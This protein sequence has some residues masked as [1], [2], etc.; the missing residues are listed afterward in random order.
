MSLSCSCDFDDPSAYAWYLEDHSNFKL[1]GVKD[2]RKR[3]CSCNDLI[4]S[5]DEVIEFYRYR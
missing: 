2:R 4:N 3:C 1:M 5:N